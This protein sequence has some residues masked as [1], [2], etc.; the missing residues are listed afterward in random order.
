M[1][2]K[3]GRSYQTMYTRRDWRVMTVVDAA[4]HDLHECERAVVAAREAALEAGTALRTSIR[5]TLNR[6]TEYEYAQSPHLYKH[7]P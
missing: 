5:P 1:K 2:E 4:L 7:S 6:L 3:Q